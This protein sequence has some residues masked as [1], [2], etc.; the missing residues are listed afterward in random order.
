M[1]DTPATMQAEDA[2]P[3]NAKIVY[4]LYLIGLL[5]GITSI[6]GVVMAYIYK[7]D[8]PAWLKDHYRWQ[9]RTFWI[10]VL[11]T[12]IGMLT[13]LILVGY[14]VLLFVLVWYIVRCVKGLQALD[15]RQP[16]ANSGSWLF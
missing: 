10:G 2:S 7:G 11:Y 6:V 13:S 5:V 4:I 3:G 8:A 14:L 1:S 9:I 16:L 12:L 15:K